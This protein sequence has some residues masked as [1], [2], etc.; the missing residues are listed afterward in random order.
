MSRARSTYAPLSAAKG[1]EPHPRRTESAGRRAGIARRG[2]RDDERDARWGTCAAIPRGDPG[3][4]S[5][6]GP[7]D[8]LPG[9]RHERPAPRG[10]RRDSSIWRHGRHQVRVAEVRLQR[11]RGPRRPHSFH[12]GLRPATGRVDARGEPP[13]S[14][15]RA[16]RSRGLVAHGRA[17]AFTLNRRRHRLHFGSANS[18]HPK[19]CPGQRVFKMA[20]VVGSSSLRRKT[21]LTG[22]CLL[23]AFSSLAWGGPGRFLGAAQG[24]SNQFQGGLG[25]SAPTPDSRG[26]T[27]IATVPVGNGP[28][29]V[30][31][32][33]GNGYAYVANSGSNTTTVISGTS[34]VATVS[35]ES[36]PLGVG[37]DSGNGYVYVANS[38]SNN[39]S[40]INGTT[41][42]ATIAVGILPYSVAYDSENGYVYVANANSKNVTVISETTVVASIAVESNPLGVGYDSGNGYVYVA[43]FYSNN[44]SVISG[45][46]VI[47][48]IPVGHDPR[49]VGY[50]SGHGYV[51]VTNWGSNTVSVIATLESPAPPSIFG[52]D[53]WVFYSTVGGIV[54]F[55]AIASTWFV[56]RKRKRRP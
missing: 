22:L 40:V 6:R 29:G 30:G 10:R 33:S 54:G 42:V 43:N 5:E 9:R 53:P 49:G 28:W 12:R 37:Y 15:R 46:A 2:H 31:F 55:V 7:A 36:F 21:A 16:R 50:D 56:L 48:T 27:V 35:V 25:T 11:A 47:G 44:V 39:V 41:I 20:M 45:I 17:M 38:Y 52:L 3:G 14:R 13:D 34:V 51:Y 8:R 23:T 32:D 18:H 1:D 26:G 19:I 24:A 4:P